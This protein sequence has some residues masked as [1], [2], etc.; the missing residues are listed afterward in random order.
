M[1]PFV[2]LLMVL[3]LPVSLNAQEFGFG[4]SDGFGF[5]DFSSPSVNISGEVK[6]EIK[7]YFNDLETADRAREIRM[8]DIFSGNLNFDASGSS[9]QG[10]INLALTP[11]FNGTSPVEIDE[12]YVRA[13]FGP[14]T[15]TGGLKKLTWGKADSFGPLDLVNPLDY[16]DLSQI[17]DPLSIK[18]SRPMLHA[19]WS[20]GSF[21]K[22]EAVFV[23]WFKGHKFA[24]HG[25][26][27]PNQMTNLQKGVAENLTETA[28][29]KIGQLM[30][31]GKINEALALKGMLENDLPDMIASYFNES[32][33]GAD[34][35]PDT[36]TLNYAQG[37]IRF[38]TTL[39]SSDLGFQYYTGRLPRPGVIIRI[40]EDFIDSF[41]DGPGPDTDK[42][43]VHVDY[44]YFHHLGLDF[45]RVIAGFN[46][47]AEAGANLTNDF[48]GNDG[49][50]HNPAFVWSLGFDRDLIAN[51]N[52]NLQGTG[53]VRF[54][55]DRVGSKI[56][57]DCEAGGK[58]S[59][60]RIT[61]IV[62][63]KFLR[64]E[65]ELKATALWGIEDGDFLVT[66]SVSWSRNS[67]CAR[68]SA[69]FFGGERDGE[70]GQYRD[71]SYV[72]MT[73]SYTF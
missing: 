12:A 67:V 22:M 45:A 8:G 48:D 11:V 19:S 58:I 3:L 41:L 40:D 50:V 24:T 20:T 42:I 47:R 37:G 44:S 65:L 33:G 31:V 59:S 57:D 68:L 25:R 56:L 72:K 39:G 73:L 51:I 46:L 10:V 21:S 7:T 43:S 9:A 71:N 32:I 52:L 1:M 4:D 28:T 18:N 16:T 2:L 14:V 17:S 38:T 53:R 13:F 49:L 66:P 55:N 23:P 6:A 29:G 5:S 30:S 35:Y 60:T 15:I 61:G 63:R 34:I 64:D 36:N 62:S 54:F 27:T 69:G 26:W 70:L